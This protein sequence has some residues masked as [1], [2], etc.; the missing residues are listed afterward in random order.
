MTH[1]PSPHRLAAGVCAAAVLA[2]FPF[3]SPQ[4]AVTTATFNVTADVET[5]CNVTAQNLNFGPYTGAEV[6]STTTI[7]ATCS[8]GTPYTIALSAGIAPGATVTTRKMTGEVGGEF[9]AYSL[10]QDPARTANWGDTPGTDTLSPRHRNRRW[11]AAD[12]LRSRPG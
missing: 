3:A 10:F 7:T 5:T 8:T 1:S 2:G 12:G 9:L 4:A 6:D 11:P